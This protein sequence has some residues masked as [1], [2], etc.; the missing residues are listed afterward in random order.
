VLSILI[1]TV[2]AVG[3]DLMFALSVFLEGRLEGR[4]RGSDK[5]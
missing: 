3:I 1:L 4:S 5:R 2:T